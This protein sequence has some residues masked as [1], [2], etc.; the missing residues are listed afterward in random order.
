MCDQL[1][2]RDTG[3]E[4]NM[5]AA[6]LALVGPEAFLSVHDDDPDPLECCLCNTDVEAILYAAGYAYEPIDG[7]PCD[8]ITYQVNH[9]D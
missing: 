4:I 2:N 5:R 3:E 9:D 8:V 7:N 6:L 1:I